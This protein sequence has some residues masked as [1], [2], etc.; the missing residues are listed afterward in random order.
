M[1]ALPP[2]RTV[3]LRAAVLGLAAALAVGTALGFEAHRLLS[4]GPPH[5]G[6]AGGLGVSG[7]AGAIETGETKTRSR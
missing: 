3:P 6:R 2:A 1:D 5:A 4:P 7:G